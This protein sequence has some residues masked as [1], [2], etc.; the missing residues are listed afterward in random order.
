[1]GFNLAFKGL[2]IN[3]LSFRSSG[4]NSIR[5]HPFSGTMALGLTPLLTEM[6]T[7]NIFW[8]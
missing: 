7:R 2:K 1:M 5:H 3:A 8:W 6:R 4:T